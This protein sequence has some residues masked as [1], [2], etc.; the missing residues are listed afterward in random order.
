MTPSDFSARLPPM[1]AMPTVSSR[2]NPPGTTKPVSRKR[3]APVEV[4]KEIQPRFK[5][6]DAE[7]IAALPEQLLLG[8]GDDPKRQSYFDFDDSKAAGNVG[9]RKVHMVL[10]RSVTLHDYRKREDGRRQHRTMVTIPPKLRANVA[11]LFGFDDVAL[12]GTEVALTTAIVALAD[13]AAAQLK[14][15]D[16]LLVVSAPSDPFAAER[17]RARMALRNRGRVK[18]GTSV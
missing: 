11:A 8:P 18:S 16:K 13:Y 6:V 9:G 14:A 1:P 5:P 4:S 7:A 3:G 10:P 2:P 12:G 15:E 17:K